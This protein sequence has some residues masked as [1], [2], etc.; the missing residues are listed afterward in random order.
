MR[1]TEDTYLRK[2]GCFEVEIEELIDNMKWHGNPKGIHSPVVH[3]LWHWK[4]QGHDRIMLVPLLTEPAV[5]GTLL[6][7]NMT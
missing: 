7:G 4:V 5:F 2:E 3:L 6:L 1:K